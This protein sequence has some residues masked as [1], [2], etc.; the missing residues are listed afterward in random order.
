[1]H[2]SALGID[3]LQV[4]GSAFLTV[5]G[6]IDG[7]SVVS[8]RAV[9]DGLPLDIRTV[10]DMSGV[11]FMDSSGLNAL[12]D[13]TLRVERTGGSLRIVSP[14]RPV[15][16]VVEITGLTHMFY[17]PEPVTPSVQRDDAAF[18]IPVVDV[19]HRHRRDVVC[20]STEQRV[21]QPWAA[22]V[23][24]MVPEANPE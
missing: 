4:E 24:G 2:E 16:R 21:Q 3:L 9:L 11:G 5:V 7:Q 1:M 13:H 23:A 15:H 8:L 17:E 18:V 6:D 12:I 10:V 14:S 20:A 19:G 22:D